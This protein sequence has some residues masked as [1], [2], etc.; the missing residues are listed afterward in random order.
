VGVPAKMK[1]F[2][3]GEQER[4]RFRQERCHKEGRRQKNRP[5]CV[6]E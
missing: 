4:Q 3:A 5:V 6:K 1:T 2:F